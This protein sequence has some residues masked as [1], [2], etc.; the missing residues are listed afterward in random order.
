MTADPN[1]RAILDSERAQCLDMLDRVYS[2]DPNGYFIR[3]FDGDPYYKNDY[4]RVYVE[5]GR[6]VSSLHICRREV[7]VGRARLVMGGIANVC[8]DPDYRRKGYSSAVLLD[9]ARLM[10]AE[11]MDFSVLFTGKHGFY[12]RV[13]WR[14]LPITYLAGKLRE[15]TLTADEEH[16]EAAPYEPDRDAPALLAV[17][18]Q[19]SGEMLMTA[20]RDESLWRNFI[21][22]KFH[23]PWRI[24]LARDRARVVAYTMSR[25]DDSTLAFDEVGF[26]PGH[27]A[28][29]SLLMK[30]AA[31]EAI[32]Q[33][34]HEVYLG[35][36]SHPGVMAIASGIAEGLE[37][38]PL[39]HTM[40][41]FF[42]PERTFRRLLPELDR[43]VK[44][45]RLTGSVTIRT[46]IGDV[47]LTSDGSHVEIAQPPE[48]SNEA[49]LT[50]PDLARL[51]FGMGPAQDAESRVS[52]GVMAFLDR[53]FPPQPFV[54]WE[55]D[56]F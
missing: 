13:G 54:Y 20:V 27:D 34:T 7:C 40:I 32:G 22:H 35:P 43:R 16:Y 33:G 23:P 3:C 8:T 1:V 44:G 31:Q 49:T 11:E 6:I 24:A 29:L 2:D 38:R 51:I 28:A 55:A 21:M 47:T 48:S 39:D 10:D 15:P 12:D 41:R 26:T 30:Q 4:C 42:N 5:D 25:L 18:E 46:E 14:T 37:T 53:L 52:E 36:A 19:S 17:H 9:S 45:S 50:Q 56:T